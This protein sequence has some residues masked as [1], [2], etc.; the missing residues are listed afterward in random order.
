MRPWCK[1]ELAMS[2]LV[3]SYTAEPG[4]AIEK[5]FFWYN[6]SGY[7]TPGSRFYSDL[8]DTSVCI[9]QLIRSKPLV[10]SCNCRRLADGSFQLT[11]MSRDDHAVELIEPSHGGPDKDKTL[12]QHSQRCHEGEFRHISISARQRSLRC[13][14]NLRELFLRATLPMTVRS[15]ARAMAD[16]RE[17]K[18][19]IT[20]PPRWVSAQ[21]LYVCVSAWWW[22]RRCSQHLC[23]PFL[24]AVRLFTL[25]N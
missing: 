6:S 13:G 25:I 9:H 12:L 24:R 2:G 18:G 5:H 10:C 7:R 15:C 11:H 8:L 22:S 4:I 1:G 19:L 3:S 21:L 17:T 14:Q 20:P 16:N 23:S